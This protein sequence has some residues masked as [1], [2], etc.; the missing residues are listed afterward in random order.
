M[1]MISIKA[2]V[3]NSDDARE[4]AVGQGRFGARGAGAAAGRI[5][6]AKSI[7]TCRCRGVGRWWSVRSTAAAGPYSPHA[8][9]ASHAL[10]VS[11]AK[12]VLSRAPPRRAGWDGFA[13]DYPVVGD[14]HG[15]TVLTSDNDLLI[16]PLL[17]D[18]QYVGH[19]W[20][21]AGTGRTIN[22]VPNDHSLPDQTG[23]QRPGTQ[24]LDP[25]AGGDRHSPTVFQA[26]LSRAE[27]R[28][29]DEGDLRHRAAL[30]GP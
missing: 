22:G 20:P 24:L 7:R 14:G 25:F 10:P 4:A 19:R 2:M 6:P 28:M 17:Q 3:R 18:S 8:L 1:E 15:L 26:R 9:P 23:M 12:V 21:A 27:A 30:R 16:A 13:G 29:E 11:S 5:S